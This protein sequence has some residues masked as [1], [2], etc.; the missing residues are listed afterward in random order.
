[1]PADAPC[2]P[3]DPDELTE[4]PEPEDEIAEELAGSRT[5]A[6]VNVAAGDAA[7][8]AEADEASSPSSPDDCRDFALGEDPHRS[9]APPRPRPDVGSPGKSAI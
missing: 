2:A 5:A 7:A 4:L 6:V 9:L 3:P 1:M 8:A